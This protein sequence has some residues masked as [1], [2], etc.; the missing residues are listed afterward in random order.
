VVIGTIFTIGLVMALVSQFCLVKPK[1]L[2]DP[3][4]AKATPMLHAR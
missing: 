3:G 2:T 4:A 1:L